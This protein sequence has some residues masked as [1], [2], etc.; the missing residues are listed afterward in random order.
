MLKRIILLLLFPFVFVT[1]NQVLAHTSLQESLPKE[2]EVVTETI[3]ELRLIFNTKI[4]QT[5][6]FGVTNSVGESLTLENFAIEENKI[7]AN[8]LQPLEN[9][10]YEVTWTIVGADGHPIKGAYS[11]SVYVPSDEEL[12]QKTGEKSATKQSI[13]EIQ[14][15]NLPSYVMPSIIG[16]LL[17][18]V[19]GSVF[20]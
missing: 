17:M 9:G 15:I 11:F 5:S 19:I 3:Q 20:R 8:F 10:S 14:Q 7:Q 12:V 2:G 4:E 1:S 18:I 6:K 16:I 13:P